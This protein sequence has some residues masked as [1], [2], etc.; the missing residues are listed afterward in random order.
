MT[1]SPSSD[2]LL[3]WLPRSPL[4]GACLDSQGNFGRKLGS[5][6]GLDAWALSCSGPSKVI[7]PWLR[8]SGASYLL[9]KE[10]PSRQP[11]WW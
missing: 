6:L 5:L 2:P 10:V 7:S 4:L 8:Q 3:P 11:T 9:P 1:L